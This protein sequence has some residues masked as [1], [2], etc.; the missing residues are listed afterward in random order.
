VG[1]VVE[2]SDTLCIKDDTEVTRIHLLADRVD[3]AKSS[4]GAT[5]SGSDEAVTPIPLTR[6]EL[7]RPYGKFWPLGWDGRVKLIALAAAVWL[8][9][10]GLAVGRVR[11][12]WPWLATTAVAMALLAGL[13]ILYWPRICFTM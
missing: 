4:A 9:A 7:H 2:G 8:P 12:S 13:L 11:R 10:L 5:P 1:I 6:C 3:I